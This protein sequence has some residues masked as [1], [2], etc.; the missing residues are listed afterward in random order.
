MSRNILCVVEFDR[1][2]EV[3][4][5]R[6]AWLA[7]ADNCNLHL[8]VCDPITDFLGDSYVY[9]LE[10][11]DIANSIRVYQ[12]EV[13]A[14]IVETAEKA[15]VNVEVSRSTERNIADVVRREAD[16]R[17]PRF[18]MKGTHYHTPSERASLD[19]T[20]W[21]LI[22]DLDYPLWFVK[23][24]AWP[25]APVI[26][27]AVDPLHARDKPA[28][29]DR[30]IITMA[31]SIAEQCKGT[32]QVLHTYQRLEEIGLRATWAFKPVKLPV[33]DIEAKIRTEHEKALKMLAET[34]DVPGKALHMLPGRANEVLPAFAFKQAAS[35]VVMGALARSKLKQRIVG[36]TAA[37]VL[38]HLHCD[39]LVAHARQGP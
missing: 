23:R 15:G 9:L 4:V 30:R 27:A 12:D 1:F 18:V 26:I 10:S 24:A 20:D 32:L 37:R 2:P 8:L 22:R 19:N 35:L 11:Q 17:K 3:V 34:C 28:H 38:D 36:S 33:E 31:R 21:E 6:A 5:E 13:L 25:K 29:L 16:A 39:V 7:S 14:E